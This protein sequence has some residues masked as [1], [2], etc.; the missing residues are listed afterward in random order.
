MLTIK[1]A[2]PAASPATQPTHRIETLDVLPQPLIEEFLPIYQTAFAPLEELAA[3]RQSFSDEEFRE[4]MADP[5][6]VKFLIWSGDEAVAL[7]FG[8]T[9]LHKMPWVSPRFYEK[10]YPDHA[11]RDAIFYGHSICVRPER[12][13]GP[14]AGLALDALLRHIAAFDGILALD[15]C[16]FNND[17][18]KIP[19]M[20]RRVSDRIGSYVVDELDCQRYFGFVFGGAR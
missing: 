6:F 16:S 15:T 11:A 2:A 4:E 5:A 13:G 9:N 19:D 3:A 14:W 12:Q 20:V 17:I 10:R 8:T 7:T 1:P 18:V